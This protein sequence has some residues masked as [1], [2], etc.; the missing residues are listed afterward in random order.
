MAFKLNAARYNYITPYMKTLGIL[1][2]TILS[3]TLLAL[4]ACGGSPGNGGNGN[5]GGG[6][7]EPLNV[8]TS[9]LY[10]DFYDQ[11]VFQLSWEVKTAGNITTKIDM[12][13]DQGEECDPFYKVVCEGVTCSLFDVYLLDGVLKEEKRSSNRSLS[14]STAE[15]DGDTISTVVLGDPYFRGDVKTVFRLRVISGS[16]ESSFKFINL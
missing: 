5:E 14:R 12:C 1:N 7:L 9:S 6:V 11:D 3:V 2:S 4:G 16:Q 10:S 13:N 8:Q 15:Q